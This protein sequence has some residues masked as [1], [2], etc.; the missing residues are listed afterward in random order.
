[1]WI[2]LPDLD[3]LSAIISLL[4][5][6]VDGKMSIDISHLVLVTLGHTGNQVVNDG[7]DSSEGGDVL[8]RAVVDVYI[9]DL[10]AILV[11]LLGKGECD[12]DVGKIFGEFACCAKSSAYCPT[13]STVFRSKVVGV[14]DPSVR[15]VLH[16]VAGAEEHMGC[17]HL[18]D[19]QL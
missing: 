8:S 4:N 10:F 18:L 9:E 7:L 12:C 11:L 13:L 15:L 16:G 14:L 3:V 1:M 5:V 6:D 19:L 17:A 2:C